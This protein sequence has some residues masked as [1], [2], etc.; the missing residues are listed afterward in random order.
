LPDLKEESKMKITSRIIKG[1]SIFP[2][3][4]LCLFLFACGAGEQSWD[5]GLTGTWSQ[6]VT[7]SIREGEIPDE[8]WQYS[9]DRV[10]IHAGDTLSFFN[11]CSTVYDFEMSLIGDDLD[12]VAVRDPDLLNVMRGT[13]SGDGTEM[14]GIFTAGTKPNNRNG[15][16]KM[17][18]ESSST[19]FRTYGAL[20]IET[21]NDVDVVIKGE[22]C[23]NIS[24]DSSFVCVKGLGE[25]N[26]PPIVI[27]S[28]HKYQWLVTNEESETEGESVTEGESEIDEE[29]EVEEVE[30]EGVLSLVIKI[31]WLLE[32][33]FESG[34]PLDIE[35]IKKDI[36]TPV[37]DPILLRG[38]LI[39]D[40]S[41]E[42]EVDAVKGTI[43]VRYYDY[44]NKELRGEF[45]VELRGG[46]NIS[47]RF[48]IFSD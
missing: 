22:N 34:K 9:S 18:R 5:Y 30:I 15:N 28:L 36:F 46:S 27:T 1:A 24:I 47:G 38:D 32:S 23:G 25:E 42:K 7:D 8:D 14:Q 40:C 44:D 20:E 31:P 41:G 16:W 3:S 12:L 19:D 48:D 33:A 6:Y 45:D 4:L 11:A 13:V 2:L 37:A 21:L 26:D 43:T 35:E 17:V 10:V 39:E 29:P